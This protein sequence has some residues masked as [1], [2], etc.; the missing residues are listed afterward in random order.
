LQDAERD[1]FEIPELEEEPE[2]FSDLLQVWMAFGTLQSG[3]GSINFSD[4]VSYMDEESID[5]DDERSTF[6][7]L[8]RHLQ[9]VRSDFDTKQLKKKG[10]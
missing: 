9:Y 6:I 2:L 3:D 10:K 1:G 8:I 7:R 4:I 5:G